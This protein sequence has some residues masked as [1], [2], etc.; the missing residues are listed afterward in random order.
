MGIYC[1]KNTTCESTTSP[2][3]LVEFPDTNSTNTA[4]IEFE[5]ADLSQKYQFSVHFRQSPTNVL[6]SQGDLK[7]E[8]ATADSSD[9]SNTSYSFLFFD[10]NT[11][12]LTIQ[13]TTVH[14]SVTF[15]GKRV[16]IPAQKTLWERISPWAM[17]II[18]MGVNMYIQSRTRN[19]F[20]TP[21]SESVATAAGTAAA[22]SVTTSRKND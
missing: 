2:H 8:T 10:R 21:P 7:V 11:F 5:T 18:A 22:E 15:I 3:V 16:D 6:V 9:S 20:S 14:A 17:V 12:T 19:A 13:P 4:K 1:E